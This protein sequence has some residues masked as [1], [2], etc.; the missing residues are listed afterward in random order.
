[1]KLQ[2]GFESIPYSS[3]YTRESPLSATLKRRRPKRLSL[4]QQG[5]GV[6]KTVGM[7]A[8]ELEKKYGIVE[9][10]YNMEEPNIVKDLE[11]AF[12]NALELGMTGG[13]PEPIWDPSLVYEP[14]FRRAISTRKFDGVIPGVPTKAAKAGVS[15]L[16]VDPYKKGAA[17]RPSFMNTTLYMRSFRAWTEK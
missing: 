8:E 3:R 6:G 17:E 5:Y 2:L 15:H 13:S 12:G 7:V 11:N 10:F 14:R 4:I 16:R 9:T 1:M